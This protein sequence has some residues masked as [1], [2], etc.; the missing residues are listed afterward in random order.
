M[1]L[2]TPQTILS[3]VLMLDA[4]ALHGLIDEA[5]IGLQAGRTSMRMNES[6]ELQPPRVQVELYDEVGMALPPAEANADP[7]TEGHPPKSLIAVASLSGVITRH[8]YMGWWSSSPGTIDIG[9]QLMKLDR[10]DAVGTIILFIN[11]PGGSAAGTPE[12]AQIVYD[13]RKANRTRIVSV[14][15]TMMASAATYIGTAAS[16]VF[17]VPSGD[18]GSIGV[19]NGYADYSEMLTKQGV[20]IE[21]C[22]VPEKKARFS[23]YEPM[24]DD[25]RE[26]LQSR[27]EEIYKVFI[28]DMARNRGVSEK[29]VAANFGQGEMMSATDGVDAKLIDGI[30][31][32]DDVISEIAMEASKRRAKRNRSASLESLKAAQEQTAALA[33]LIEEDASEPETSAG[34][35]TAETAEATTEATS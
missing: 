29:Y 14:V 1:I 26:T 18:V 20:K 17:A 2:A 24:T 27:I 11:S 19:I 35:E 32:I 13:L 33:A 25:M 3:D 9:R 30:A 15:D 23:G 10:D 8:G 4:R 16:E 28:T 31:S 21:Y 34:D 6:G 7:S 12:L 5:R 22:R